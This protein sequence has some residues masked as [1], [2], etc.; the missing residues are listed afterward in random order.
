[1]ESFLLIMV[2]ILFAAEIAAIFLPFL[3]DT[4]FFW[5]AVLLYRFIDSNTVYSLYFCLGAVLITIIIL[6]ADYFS[7]LYFIKKRGGSNRTVITAV[8]AMIFGTI[9]LGPLGFILLPFI[10]IFLIEFWKSRNKKNSF[11]LALSTIFAFFAGTFVK[12]GMQ[13]FLMLWFFIEVY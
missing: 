4:V 2:I 10:S 3:P 12:L 13:L 11:K 9:F 1:M 7:N 5:S 6:S 8:L